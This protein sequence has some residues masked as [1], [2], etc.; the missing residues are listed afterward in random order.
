M[1]CWTC[2][3]IFQVTADDIENQRRHGVP[4]V[5]VAINRDTADIHLDETRFKGLEVFFL[6]GECVV[7]A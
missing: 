3:S 4:D 5:R 2:T 7:Y 1:T 6:A